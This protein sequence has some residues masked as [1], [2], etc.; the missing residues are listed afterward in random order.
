[1][2]QSS[3]A[4]AVRSRKRHAFKV[5]QR[6]WD[7]G[8]RL[9]RERRTPD[10]R[11]PG[12]VP[13]TGGSP[14]TPGAY[15]DR[16]PVTTPRWRTA[17]EP[18][19]PSWGSVTDTGSMEP[20][21]DAVAWAVRAD[22][23]SQRPNSAVEPS[24]VLEAPTNRWSEVAATGRP[25]FP[26]EGVGWRSATSEWR[27]TTESRWRQTTEWRSR[28]GTSGWR[29]TTE[30]WQAAGDDAEEIRP[31][32]E[33][34][35]R[36]PAISGTAWPTPQSDDQPWSPPQDPAV[37]PW[38]Q[39]PDSRPPW[40]SAA[41]PT[42]SWQTPVPEGTPPADPR[43]P[44]QTPRA[45]PTTPADLT[46]AWQPPR[47]EPTQVTPP[48]QTPRSEPTPPA[49]LTPSWQT[50]PSDPAPSWQAP[51]ADPAPSWQTPRADPTPSRQQ[52]ADTT[53]SWQTP[54]EPTPSWQQPA[55]TTPSW[56]RPD[57]GTPAGSRPSWQTPADEPTPSWRTPAPEPAPSWRA[58]TQA[59]PSWQQPADAR[60]SWQRPESR[61]S[62]QSGTEPTSSGRGRTGTGRASA[63]EPASG[64]Y[65]GAWSAPATFDDGRHLVR[66][67]D[68]AQWRRDA[69]AGRTGAPD[70]PSRV[71]RRRAPE[72]DGPQPG[73][74]TGWAV[75][76][77]PDN[78]AGHTDTGNIPVFRDSDGRD[79]A[80]W[81]RDSYEPGPRDSWRTRTSA[82]E[83]RRGE[84]APR[85]S[86]PQ[87]DTPRWESG[88][89]GAGQARRDDATDNGTR[90]RRAELPASDPWAR[91]AGDTGTGPLAWQAPEDTGTGSWRS[92]PDTA[93]W[94]RYLDDP[95]DAPGGPRPRSGAGTW[96]P[97]PERR[98]RRRV[99]DE[100]ETGRRADFED[101]PRAPRPP[102]PD[103]RARRRAVPE[104][105][106]PEVWD[107]EPENRQDDDE[108]PRA[109]R[110]P[111][112]PG[113]QDDDRTQSW[114]RELQEDLRREGRGQARGPGGPVGDATEVL[115]AQ[116]EPGSW[117]LEQ[118][119]QAA[120]G[121]ASYR[122]G[123]TDD[124]RQQLA[125]QAGASG[126]E[127]R[128]PGSAEFPRFRPPGSGTPEDDGPPAVV[129]A[130]RAPDPAGSRD[131]GP[132]EQL[133]VGS[134]SGG[135][136]S[137][138]DPPD[139]QWPPRRAVEGG[140]YQR[141]STA[142]AGPYERR[143]VS[144]LPEA[145]GRQ[146]SL[147]E[148]DD[149][150]LED[151]PGGPLAAVGFTAVWYSVPVV[152]FVLYMLVLDGAQQA[153]ALRT[154]AGAAPQFGLSLV[155]SMAVAVGLRWASGSWKAAS[156]G[157]AA[158]VMGGGLATVLNSAIT[159]QS[160]T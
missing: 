106:D 85:S 88:S 2:K 97:A 73:G 96:Q 38:Q 152:L 19:Q 52:P 126:G 100:D 34:L 120:R 14:A 138:Q 49:D 93:T 135:E 133:L 1:M 123:N 146:R 75:R 11:P 122:E 95:E 159:G 84:A 121:T 71:G 91:D 18:D 98:P 82:A 58:G 9:P 50:P 24:S 83:R 132:R 25:A 65:T 115:R 86:A 137:W 27:S 30:A 130:V 112:R 28:S 103:D 78:W 59:A 160:L 53:A 26:P 64:P 23:W 118:R 7:Y 116:P 139:T 124:W 47:A 70:R 72:P 48:W 39:Q 44:W 33:P 74:G 54:A 147:L 151:D 131:S 128:R 107:P 21:P 6:E 40:Q 68:R 10:A 148:P 51:R 76:S 143:P 114:R 141:G 113:S 144:T 150:D 55:D 36:L 156:V 142:L 155:L 57:G 46:P 20:I 108:E 87:G 56:R 31:P 154:L 77:E 37:P 101:G 81:R 45:G 15:A 69:A 104:P 66:E 119:D 13:E 129:A 3:Q 105:V 140:G 79:E 67:D 16:G 8:T 17:A 12:N 60:P 127:G 89:R 99:E 134:R 63:S 149:E 117:R 125:A 102:R 41:E 111:W 43:P 42:S 61:P 136:A 4:V 94:R 90:R 5:D 110:P 35:T 29:S 158:A 109:G 80:D 32:T 62:W 92:T 157:L 153:Q 22:A 145:S